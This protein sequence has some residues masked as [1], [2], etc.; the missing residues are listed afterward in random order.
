MRRKD[1]NKTVEKDTFDVVFLLA[2][3]LEFAAL[4]KSL[5]AELSEQGL[6]MLSIV[7]IT[8]G[9]SWREVEKT[10][11]SSKLPF[12]KLSDFASKTATDILIKIKPKL[13]V[14]DNDLMNIDK[15]FVLSGQRLNIPTIVIRETK[16]V[17]NDEVNYQWMFSEIAAKLNQFPRLMRTYLFYIRSMAAVK[18]ILVRNIRT[19]FLGLLRGFEGGIVG[20]YADYILANSPEDAEALRQQCP[21][22]KFVRAIGN[23]RF[24][25]TLIVART[26]TKYIRKKIR[27]KFNISQNKK[28]VLFLSGSQVEH[29][30]LAAEQKISANR[31][32][33][34]VFEGL[35]NATEV[36]IKLHP[37]EKNLFPLSWKPAYNEF[38]HITNQ[39][40]TELIIASDIIIS[41]FSTAMINVVIARKPLIVIDF[42]SGRFEGG[43]LPSIQAIADQHAAL[44]ARNANELESNL[45][46]VLY[47]PQIRE[48]LKQAQD[49]FHKSY[50]ETTD[51]KSIIR[52]AQIIKQITNQKKEQSSACQP[53]GMASD[54]YA[55]STT[56]LRSYFHNE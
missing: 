11:V 35:R 26:E 12:I 48:E 51:G 4:A 36:I 10:L 53:Q 33:L 42:F 54:K 43:I 50:L 52:I 8:A 5:C 39:D 41:W 29:G 13:I 16:S 27:E 6:S 55:N 37:I 22:S 18:P 34:S 38:V 9:N 21:N 20:T 56:Y 46:S 44:E 40:L 24:D 17:L 7:T 45:I 23:P 49:T 31:D 19:L 28:T 32:I 15:T 30:G 25:E 47:N 2:P 14:T 3:R 1:N